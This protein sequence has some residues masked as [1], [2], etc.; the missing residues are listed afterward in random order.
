MEK[1]NGTNYV[2][3]MSQMQCKYENGVTDGD[4]PALRGH[5]D[6]DLLN[7]KEQ[8][9]VWWFINAFEIKHFF[10]LIN[11]VPRGS[12]ALKVERMLHYVVPH[13]LHSRANIEDWLLRNW[14]LYPNV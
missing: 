7:R 2:I 14:K 8:Y 3:A 13:H 12:V 6:R 10:G 4:N 5:P 9:E 1:F 11:K